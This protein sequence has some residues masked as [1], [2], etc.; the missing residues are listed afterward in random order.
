MDLLPATAS[1][2]PLE[3][4]W[5]SSACNF[6]PCS[7]ISTSDSPLQTE[8]EAGRER[9]IFDCKRLQTCHRETRRTSLGA[10]PRFK[11]V[12]KNPTDSVVSKFGP[13]YLV[14]V[15]FHL[16]EFFFLID[17]LPGLFCISSLHTFLTNWIYYYAVYVSST[18]HH[19]VYFGQI[20]NWWITIACIQPHLFVFYPSGNTE[21][22]AVPALPAEGWPVRSCGRIRLQWLPPQAVHAQRNLPHH[23]PPCRWVEL[24]CR[25]DAQVT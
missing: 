22:Q 9:I 14:L 3:Y 19:T 21:S 10:R 7:P 18:K 5:F 17:A 16:A 2:V 25:A 24:F 6:G 15:S 23:I 11:D 1:P 12:W 8:M 13:P 20:E 4:T